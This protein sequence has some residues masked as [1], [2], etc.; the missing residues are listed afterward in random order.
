MHDGSA[1]LHG[2]EGRLHAIGTKDMR[3]VWV[4]GDGHGR[5]ALAD[6]FAEEGLMAEVNAVEVADGDDAAAH[7]FGHGGVEFVGE[8]GHESITRLAGELV[9]R[10]QALP[11]GEQVRRLNNHTCYTAAFRAA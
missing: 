3:D 11:R 4:E 7:R 8:G 10:G 1:F 5:S 6:G 2:R 9:R